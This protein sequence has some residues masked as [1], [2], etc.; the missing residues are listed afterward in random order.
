MADDAIIE[1]EVAR[2]FAAMQSGDPDNTGV[3]VGEAAG[4]IRDVPRA[5]D[6]VQRIVSEAEQLLAIKAPRFV[7]AGR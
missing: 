2:Y 4:I 1:R 5:G 6:V 3:W 7:K